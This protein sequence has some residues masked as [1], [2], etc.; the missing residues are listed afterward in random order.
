MNHS[1]KEMYKNLMK[2]LKLGLGSFHISYVWFGGGHMGPDAG[3]K[4]LW[5]IH[6]SVDD[7]M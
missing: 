2:C 5:D 4:D 1:T 3:N 6:T 7:L